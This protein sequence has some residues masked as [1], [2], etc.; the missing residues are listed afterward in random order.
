[1]E[2]IK[3]LQDLK[4]KDI[5]DTAKRVYM[6]LNKIYKYAVTLEYV[7]HNI[8]ADNEQKIVIGKVEKNHYPTFTKEKDIKG[9][10]QNL[11]KNSTFLKIERCC[12]SMCFRTFEWILK[13]NSHRRNPQSQLRYILSHDTMSESLQYKKCKHTD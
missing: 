11:Q 10:D 7:P 12:F 5:L 2:Y 13:E 3:K 1:M 8:I 4:S 9:F 6:L